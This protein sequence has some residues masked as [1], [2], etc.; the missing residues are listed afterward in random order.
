MRSNPFSWRRLLTVLGFAG[1]KYSRRKR[2]NYRRRPRFEQCEDRR[3]LATFTV[4]NDDDAQIGTPAAVGTLRQ[5]IFDA[6]QTLEADTIEFASNLANAT[7]TL[8]Q[9]Q[10]NITSEMTIDGTGRNITLKAHDPDQDGTNDGDGSRILEITG[11]SYTDVTLK[12]LT[13]TGG[14]VTGDGG[15][16]KADAILTIENCVVKENHAAGTAFSGAGGGIYATGSLTVR[17]SLITGNRSNSFGGGTRFIGNN[18]TVT[19]TIFH[20]NHSGNESATGALGGGL[21]IEASYILAA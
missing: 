13:L 6:D 4:M 9:G 10:L 14:D 16:I 18:L 5:A 12:H 19:S 1:D 17:D 2:A 3:L 15:A 21:S 7:I 8:T 11:G 20:D